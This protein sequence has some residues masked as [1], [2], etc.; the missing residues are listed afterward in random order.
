LTGYA[1]KPFKEILNPRSIL[2]IFEQS[3]DWHSRSDEKPSAAHLIGISFNHGTLTPTHHGISF[4][5]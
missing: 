2:K 3:A 4:I 1:R 5:I